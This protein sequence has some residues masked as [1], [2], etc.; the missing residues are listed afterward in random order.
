MGREPDM[1]IGVNAGIGEIIAVGSMDYFMEI[2]AHAMH[3][4][5]PT[6]ARWITFVPLVLG[7]RF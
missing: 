2:R 5:T 3:L 6:G 7:A 4:L 1:A